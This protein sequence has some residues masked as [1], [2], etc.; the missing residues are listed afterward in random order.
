MIHH[1]GTA[2]LGN[3][4]YGILVGLLSVGS[5]RDGDSSQRRDDSKQRQDDS[6]IRREA[7]IVTL[8]MV[9]IIVGVG[10]GWVN[11]VVPVD[12]HV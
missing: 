5:H 7:G 3:P 6:R 1:F 8:R 11:V 4:S 10:G 9:W 2:N 12:V